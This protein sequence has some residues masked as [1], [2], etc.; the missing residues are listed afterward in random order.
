MMSLILLVYTMVLNVFR[1]LHTLCCMIMRENEFVILKVCISICMVVE[2]H[3]S[4]QDRKK[5]CVLNSVAFNCQHV[6]F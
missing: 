2:C 6:L 5:V 3:L 1:A 4:F